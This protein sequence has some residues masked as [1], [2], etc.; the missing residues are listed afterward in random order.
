E[1]DARNVT[2]GSSVG[3][4]T[5]RAAV[6]SCR[7]RGSA[8]HRPGGPIVQRL[9]RF[10][11]HHRRAVLGVWVALLVAWLGLANVAGGVFKVDFALP[12]SETQRAIDLLE[13]HGFTERSGA[14]GLIVIEAPQGLDVPAVR[15]ASDRLFASV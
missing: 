12:G 10:S 13:A 2:S 9:A 11:F 3:R 6:A 1:G 5:S 8:S 7:R 4:V 15:A 14:R